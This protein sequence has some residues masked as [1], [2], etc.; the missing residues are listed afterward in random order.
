MKT[1]N[2]GQEGL[3]ILKILGLLLTNVR[4]NNEKLWKKEIIIYEGIKCV[5]KRIK[6][7]KVKN[8]T[9]F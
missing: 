3:I 7:R 9:K 4:R 8:L 1:L 6:S 5:L 2:T